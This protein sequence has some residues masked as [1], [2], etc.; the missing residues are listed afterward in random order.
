MTTPFPSLL[1]IAPLAS[2]GQAARLYVP[3]TLFNRALGFLRILLVASILGNAGKPVFGQYRLALEAINWL[4]ALVLFGLADVAERYAA[5]FERRARLLPFVKRQLLRLLAAG[6]A[7]G[8]LVSAIA[9]WTHAPAIVIAIAVNVIVLAL[10]QWLVGLLRG[11]RAY[12]AAA[13]METIGTLLLVA[14]AALAA[15]GG[16]ATALLLAYLAAN[17]V[18]AAWFGATLAAHLKLPSPAPPATD[19]SPPARLERFARWALLRLLLTMSFGL[20]S[21]W[22]V[23]YL[24]QRAAGPRAADAAAAEYALPYSIA[25][26]L[27]YASVTLWASNYALAAKAWAHGQ[28]RR[29]MVQLL[30]IGRFGGI[31][32]LVLATALT[33][34]RDLLIAL[35]PARMAAYGASLNALLPG[36]L[37]VFLWYGMLALLVALGDLQERPWIGALLWGAAVLLQLLIVALAAWAGPS[38]AEQAKTIALAASAAGVGAAVLLVA[39]LLLWRPARLTATAVPLIVVL[40]A[41]LSFFTPAWVVGAMV[42]ATSLLGLGFLWTTGLMKK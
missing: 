13:G 25:Q 2:P 34:C 20:V 32:L 28:R 18:A 30:R 3:L 6:L 21:L 9:P 10:Y 5:E 42:G 40:L 19:P 1:R 35:L 23:K 37:G 38:T 11:L 36:L 12:A 26:L 7:T 14:F 29:A 24:A 4:T 8:L 33:L 22:S 16:S 39:P 41:G 31:A 15:L 17:A 27:A